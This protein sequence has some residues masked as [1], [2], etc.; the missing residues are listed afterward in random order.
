MM[1]QVACCMKQEDLCTQ[2]DVVL[3]KQKRSMIEQRAL[4]NL[5]LPNIQ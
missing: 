1:K 5:I 2:Q 4:C 3:G